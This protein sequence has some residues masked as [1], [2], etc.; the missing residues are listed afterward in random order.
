MKGAFAGAVIIWLVLG[1][2]MGA[3]WAFE[4]YPDTSML[5]L[6]GLATTSI[7]AAFGWLWTQ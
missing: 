2:V 7:G 4:T 1:V 5:V 6:F 3:V